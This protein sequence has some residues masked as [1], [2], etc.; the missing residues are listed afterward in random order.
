MEKLYDIEAQIIIAIINDNK[1]NFPF[2]EEHYRYLVV[3]SRENTGV[4]FY[5]Y[6]SYTHPFDKGNINTLLS[7]QKTLTVD[8]FEDEL[9][10]V[11]D[12]TDGYIDCLEIVTNGND[13]FE[14][15]EVFYKF[16]LKE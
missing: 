10:Y 13:M 5:I 9:S 4:G 1:N 16:N 14:K 3:K 6:F 8:G 15:D 7:S 12:I 11:L 2:L